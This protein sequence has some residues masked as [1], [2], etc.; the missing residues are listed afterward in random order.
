[1]LKAN[2]ILA[3]PSG[4]TLCGLAILKFENGSLKQAATLGGTI[5]CEKQNG[6]SQVFGLTVGHV[7]HNQSSQPEDSSSSD[8]SDDTDEDSDIELEPIVL[9]LSPGQAFNEMQFEVPSVRD[10]HFLGISWGSHAAESVPVR[11]M[12]PDPQ[13]L[14]TG[15]YLDWGLM[16]IADA[17][18]LAQSL[19][20]C[21]LNVQ[22]TTQIRK[23]TNW[24]FRTSMSPSRRS[25]LVLTYSDYGDQSQLAATLS[26]VPSFV[27]L[28][29]GTEPITVFSLSLS[30]SSPKFLRK[31]DC[32]A[33]VID[34]TSHEV[35]GQVVALDPF[36]DVLIICLE[37]IFEDIKTSLGFKDVSIYNHESIVLPE[38][39]PIPRNNKAYL[40]KTGSSPHRIVNDEIDVA[41]AHQS[42][43]HSGSVERQIVD[44]AVVPLKALKETPGIRPERL[45]AA[46]PQGRQSDQISEDTVIP[47]GEP[48][49]SKMLKNIGLGLFFFGLAIV[50]LG[51]LPMI[52]LYARRRKGSH[53]V[54][55]E[56]PPP[57]MD[58]KYDPL[59]PT[60]YPPPPELSVPYPF[61]S[62]PYLS[63]ANELDSGP[64]GA[65]RL[66][67]EL[68]TSELS[69]IEL[70]ASEISHPVHRSKSSESTKVADQH[71]EEPTQHD[72][73]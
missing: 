17:P 37:H 44:A 16:E 3:Q 35:Y 43:G 10:H 22:K 71:A 39:T 38:A 48:K 20:N 57:A 19:Q 11:S 60:T 12:I 65:P 27:K 41:I 7:F 54:T 15:S 53:R 23:T 4:A 49:M 24:D 29:Y 14:E 31:G 34:A 58:H 69:A 46:E 28:G 62:I 70:E 25:V 50:S 59:F 47:S 13:S 56:A 32:G 40:R 5:L 68:P 26:L 21:L 9:E 33:W 2:A 42:K 6:T 1:M 55:I 66:F 64:A 30:Q 52:W 8:L 72:K 45:E 63:S 67:A 51:I 61:R 73:A 18:K 36:G